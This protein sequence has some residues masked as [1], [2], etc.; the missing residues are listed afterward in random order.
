MF[1]LSQ[2]VL[3]VAFLAVLLPIL[4]VLAIPA[5]IIAAIY[6]HHRE[7]MAYFS[8]PP[9]PPGA[10]PYAPP[11]DSEAPPPEPYRPPYSYAYREPGYSR[12]HPALY[13]PIARIGTLIGVGLGITLGFLTLGLGPLLLAGLIPLFVGLIRLGE[14]YLGPGAPPP[15]DSDLS[16]WLHRSL[17][18][19]GIGLALLLGLLTLG[20]TPLLLVGT[21]PLGY[22]LGLVLAWALARHAT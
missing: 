9:Y 10:D 5:I 18:T 1:G 14:L 16:V 15:P 8:R 7:R 17:W 20:P 19:G 4:A 22:A 6:F 2:S 11:P 12:H 21:V 3:G 13:H